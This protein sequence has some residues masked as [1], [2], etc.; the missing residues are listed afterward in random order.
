MTIP[1]KTGGMILLTAAEPR[2]GYRLWLSFSDGVEGEIDLSGFA[3]D[4]VFQVWNDRACF[5]S[6]RVTSYNAVAWTEDAELCADALYMQLTG[7]SAEELM[8]HRRPLAADA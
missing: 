5:E 6:A 8:P 1:A 3:G 4:G 2:E 7:T